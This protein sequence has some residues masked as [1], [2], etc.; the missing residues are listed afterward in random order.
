MFAEDKGIF[1]RTGIGCIDD[2]AR[3]KQA[4]YREDFS[5]VGFPNISGKNTSAVYPTVLAVSSKSEH[6]DSV[7]SVLKDLFNPDDKESSY[8]FSANKAVFEAGLQKAAKEIDEKS[9]DAYFYSWWTDEKIKRQPMSQEEIQKFED[10]VLSVD[11]MTNYNRDI[12]SIVDEESAA[13]FGGQKTAEQVADII[14]NRVS[15]YI[16]E[17]S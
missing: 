8:E 2:Y 6:L 11:L 1:Y 15:V 4:M 17:N 7:Y 3:L 13:F 10:Y 12:G 14:Q 9:D 5:L 16:N